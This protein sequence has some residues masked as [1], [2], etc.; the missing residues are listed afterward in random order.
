MDDII[1]I[2]ELAKECGVTRQTAWNRCHRL[3]VKI[4][5]YSKSTHP[6]RKGYAGFINKTDVEKVKKYVYKTL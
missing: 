1:S 3:G 2:A 5:Y 6:R 4:G